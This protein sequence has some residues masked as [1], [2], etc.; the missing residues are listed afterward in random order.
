MFVH[1]FVRIDKSMTGVTREA[2]T[3]YPAEPSEFTPSFS[4][5]NVSL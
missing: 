1:N 5:V 3:T 4:W 2:G